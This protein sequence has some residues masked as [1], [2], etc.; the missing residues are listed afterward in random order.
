MT[1]RRWGVGGSTGFIIITAAQRSFWSCLNTKHCEPNENTVHEQWISC[2]QPTWW[3]AGAQNVLF[4]NLTPCFTGL[5]L[6]SHLAHLL[7]WSGRGFNLF[8]SQPPSGS[9]GC[10]CVFRQKCTDCKSLERPALQWIYRY[11]APVVLLSVGR[12]HR[13]NPGVQEANLTSGNTRGKTTARPQPLLVYLRKPQVL[14]AANEGASNE[15]GNDAA[16][17]HE[18]V[19]SYI[20]NAACLL[21]LISWGGFTSPDCSCFLCIHACTCRNTCKYTCVSERGGYGEPC[22]SL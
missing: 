13:L 4:F 20:F 3:D 12:K 19:R 21:S 11:T 15:A 5:Q 7:T 9:L 22:R 8:C 10:I 17:K 6:S 1:S 2:C 18:E 14:Q 16:A